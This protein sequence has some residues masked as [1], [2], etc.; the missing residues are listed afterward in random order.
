MGGAVRGGNLYGRFPVL[1]TK[2]A[3]NNNFDGSADQLGNG[4]LLPVSSVDQLGATLARW[5]GVSEAG[6][7]EIFQ[8]LANWNASARDLGFLN[9]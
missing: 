2:N 5:M 3:A 9:A 1:A 7:T 6:V 8:N 4:S